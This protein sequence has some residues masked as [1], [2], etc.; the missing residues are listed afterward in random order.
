M[1][2]DKLNI[3]EYTVS[4]LSQIVFKDMSENYLHLINNTE[5]LTNHLDRKFIY[6]PRQLEVLLDDIED[7]KG[8]DKLSYLGL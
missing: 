4:V 7:Y 3:S 1:I 5:L 2:I 6:H 8:G